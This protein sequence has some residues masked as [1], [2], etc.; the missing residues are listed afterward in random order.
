[1]CCRTGWPAGRS[2]SCR[3]VLAKSGPARRRAPGRP[4]RGA[5]SVLPACRARR[6]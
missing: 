2:A 4:R 6:R 5:G 3:P 1:V